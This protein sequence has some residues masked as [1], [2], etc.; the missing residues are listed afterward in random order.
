MAEL[1]AVATVLVLPAVL[2]LGL[3]FG[4]GLVV[5]TLAEA[6]DAHSRAGDA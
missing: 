3:L 5:A 6:A 1:V 4:L 2:V